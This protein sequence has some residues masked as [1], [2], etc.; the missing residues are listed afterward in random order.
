MTIMYIFLNLSLGSSGCL[1]ALDLSED[2]PSAT[3]ISSHDISDGIRP[4][5]SIQ[6]LTETHVA[7]A[8][9]VKDDQGEYGIIHKCLIT[10][11]MAEKMHKKH[12]FTN[13]KLM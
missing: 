11:Y 6:A 12:S 3:P 5:T 7:I 8:G 10:Y 2:S 1:M 4:G 9:L 13:L